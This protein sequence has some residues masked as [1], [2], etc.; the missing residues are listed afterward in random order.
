MISDK[1]YNECCDYL[2]ELFAGL[3]INSQREHFT[4]VFT[5]PNA[6]LGERLFSNF[7]PLFQFASY[8]DEASAIHFDFKMVQDDSPLL[9]KSGLESTYNKIPRWFARYLAAEFPETSVYEREH[10]DQCLMDAAVQARGIKIQEIKSFIQQAIDRYQNAF[11][12]L[13]S[14]REKNSILIK[15]SHLYKVTRNPNKLAKLL[16]EKEPPPDPI[17]ENQSSPVKVPLTSPNVVEEFRER[18]N[19]SREAIKKITLSPISIKMAPISFSS[20]LGLLAGFALLYWIISSDK[21][22]SYLIFLNLKSFFFVVLGTIACTMISY[23]GL[24]IGRAFREILQIFIPTHV[25]PKLLLNDVGTLIHWSQKF[26]AHQYVRKSFRELEDLLSHYE[27]PDCSFTKTA[28]CYLLEQYEAKKLNSLLNNLVNTM[29]D[30]S[31]VQVRIIRTMGHIAICFGALGTL[32][33]IVIVLSHP[34]SQI[35]QFS[36]SIASAL[37]PMVYGLVLAFILFKPAARKLEQKNEMRRYRNQL[38]SCGFVL[39]TENKSAL[40]IQDTLNSFLDPL[41]HFHIVSRKG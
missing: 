38:L 33:S 41:G 29:F 9:S 5:V 7:K 32:I 34:Y 23:H 15:M 21:E 19:E 10:F 24:Y 35:S 36:N 11:Q 25:G 22:A 27:D 37:V 31:Q 1:H 12:N 4:Y 17:T 30:S 2:D 3:I 39:L 14:Y 18:I 16:Q 8:H 28:I 26:K 20:L 40:E 6:L 13:S